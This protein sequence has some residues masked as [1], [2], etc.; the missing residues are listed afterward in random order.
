MVERDTFDATPRPD[1][2]QAHILIRNFHSKKAPDQ[3]GQEESRE[4]LQRP[5]P[6]WLFS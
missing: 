6:G 4:T 1:W 2:P 5:F 3:P